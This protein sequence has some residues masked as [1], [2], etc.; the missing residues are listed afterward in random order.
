M[1]VLVIFVLSVI[2]Y[3]VYDRT[4]KKKKTYKEFIVGKK[5]SIKGILVGLSFGI[6]FGFLDNFGLLVGMDTLTKN[7][8]MDNT[9]KS[10]FGNTYSDFIGAT[11]GTFISIILKQMLN[12]DGDDEPIWLDSFGIVIG[13]LLGYYVPVYVKRMM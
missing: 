2:S 8:K 11:V 12:Y 7:F 9:Q 4:S 6:V 5:M 13:C 10:A 1:N 3:K